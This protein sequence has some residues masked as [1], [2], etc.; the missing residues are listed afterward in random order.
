MKKKSFLKEYWANSQ[1]SVIKILVTAV[2]AITVSLISTQLSSIKAIYLTG[3]IAIISLLINEI[4]NFIFRLISHGASVA[5]EKIIP[6]EDGDNE[7]N[8]H[9]NESQTESEESETDEYLK[10]SSTQSVFRR[11]GDFF[12]HHQNIRLI[13]F[14]VAVT[15]IVLAI[16]AYS[17]RVSQTVNPM[18]TVGV[19]DGT[20]QEIVDEAVNKALSNTETTIT[21]LEEKA[22]DNSNDSTQSND[23]NE[24][25]IEELETNLESNRN[26]LE[27]SQEDLETKYLNLLEKYSDLKNLS[28]SQKGEISALKGEINSLVTQINDIQKQ[29]NELLPTLEETETE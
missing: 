22:R 7:K 1:V 8:S 2:A 13:I 14:F 18:V 12:N 23:F 5:A 15:G 20:K 4:Y 10:D 21:E 9:A 6:K 17:P 25:K 28:E 27:N 3:V 19:D 26:S 24:Q 11:F 16:N 29:L